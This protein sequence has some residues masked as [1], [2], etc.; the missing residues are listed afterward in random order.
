[1]PFANATARVRA[2]IEAH[3]G[4]D[5][6]LRRLGNSPPDDVALVVKVDD[7]DD[8][9]IGGGVQQFRRTVIASNLEIST[10]SWPGPPRRGD[11]VL[12]SSGTKTLTVQKVD[13]KVLNG[14]R[15]MHVM[16]TLGS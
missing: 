5:A 8:I 4:Q 6:I 11:L 9:P 7:V 14:V 16:T 2:M 13:T 1:M 3:G 12:I 10:A 15:I